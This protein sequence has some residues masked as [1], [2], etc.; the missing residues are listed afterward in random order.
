MDRFI[1]L[2]LVFVFQVQGFRTCYSPGPAFPPASQILNKTHFSQLGIKLD[3][4]IERILSN[5][6]G[7]TTNTTSF[8]VQLTS[9]DETIWSHYYTAPILGQYKDSDSAPVTGDTAFRIASISKSFTVY[10][11]LLEKGINLE[12]PITKYLPELLAGEK[13]PWHVQWDQISIRSLASQ[14]SGISR[15]VGLGELAVDF[16]HLPD[17]VAEGF[18]PI[19][20]KD[21]PPCMKNGKDRPCNAS[22]IVESAMSRW[23]VFSPN[24]RSTYSNVAFSL[25]GMVLENVTGNSYS[26]VISHSI[27]DPLN[28]TNTR[29]TK[30]KDSAGIIPYGPN[31]WEATLGADDPSG[32]IY[33][34]SNDFSRYLRSILSSTLLPRNSTNAW[35]KPHSWTSSGTNSAYG[36][37]WEM[38]RTTKGTPDGR[39]IDI[40]TKGGSLEG[41]F[42]T[43]AL[44]PEFGLG[45]SVLVAG[46]SSAL[47]DLLENFTAEVIFTVDKLLRDEVRRAYCGLWTALDDL[48]SGPANMDWSFRIEVDETGPG[49]RITDWKS[50]G[51]DFLPVYGK[52]KG[53]P[54]DPDQWEARLLPTVSYEGHAGLTKK[55]EIWRLTAIPKRAATDK[56][57]IWEDYCMTDVDG[58]MYGG[59]SVEEFGIFVAGSEEKTD[60]QAIALINSGLRTFLVKWTDCDG[61]DVDNA[62]ES[63][64]YS[65][66]EFETEGQK[67]IFG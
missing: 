28:M 29:T 47:L 58:L 57:K 6:D 63:L 61:N 64:Q 36:M 7:W 50:N 55:L 19:E 49:L 31:D 14:L 51:T 60:I 24:D 22:E 12:D 17:P 41:Y 44:L 46:E 67:P 4:V 27:L 25:L 53:M 37:P 8:A 43:I 40:I 1:Y 20:E 10:A 45:L 11:I 21:I 13:H 65:K 5:P 23:K 62:R 3:N 42:S 16:E 26:D 35:M 59:A 18:P 56:G 34:T 15:E 2:L 39:P 9:S 38:L 32:G 66:E 52:L 30:P 54:A 48:W 33:T